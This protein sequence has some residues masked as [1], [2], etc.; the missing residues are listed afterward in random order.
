MRRGVREVGI[1]IVLIAA[2]LAEHNTDSV[3][4]NQSPIDFMYG[5]YFPKANTPP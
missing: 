2:V 5:S 1:L 3:R 4:M